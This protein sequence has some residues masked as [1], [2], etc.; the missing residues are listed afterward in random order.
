MGCSP[1]M[2]RTGPLVRVP[3]YQGRRG[4]PIRFSRE[5]IAEF[6]TSPR[7]ARPAISCAVAR[8]KP[9]P[10]RRRPGI[11]ADIDDAPLTAPHRSRLMKLRLGSFSSSWRLLLVLVIAGF[12]APVFTVDQFGRRCRPR[13]SA[14][15]AAA[16]NRQSAF[17]SLQSPVFGG[18][19]HHLR[20]SAIGMEPVV[21]I[22]SR[23]LDGGGAQHLVA[24]GGRFVIASIRLDGP[25]SISR[26]RVRLRS[27][28]V[29]FASII[30][31]R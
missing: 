30:N 20:R 4:H 17:Q 23:R 6:W 19:R 11:L 8:R 28:T 16:W 31:P 1:G 27:G 12:V 9:N 2:S 18:Q 25:A 3:R 22:Q 10:G 29:N 26:N 14:L 24:I 13:W 5:L 7:T 21:Y 15:S